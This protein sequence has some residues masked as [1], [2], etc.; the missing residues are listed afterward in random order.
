MH[1]IKPVLDLLL[2][3]SLA[4][5]I[6]L[7]G[8]IA[9]VAAAAFFVSR[10][11]TPAV[12]AVAIV[13]EVFSGNWKYIHIPL[14]AD[15]LLMLFGLFLLFWRGT[16]ELGSRKL[17]FSPIHLL[18]CALV[19]YVV[20]SAWVT[21]TLESSLGFYAILDRLGVVPFIM[22]AVAPLVFYTR[23]ARNTLLVA[24]VLLGAYLGCTAVAEGIPVHALIFPRY[25]ADPMLG[26]HFGRARGPFLEGVADGLSMF[27]CGTAAAVA[28]ASWTD[29]RARLLCYGVIAVSI[30]GGIFTLTRTVWVG[31]VFGP[32]IAMLWNPRLRRWIPA[33][34]AGGAVVILAALFLIPGLDSK[35]GGRASEVSPIWDRYNTNDAAIRAFVAHP[36][37]GIGWEE[38]V[39]KGPD[40]LRQADTY[41]LTGS[42]LEVHNVFLSHLVELGIPGLAM[43]A[44]AL[45]STVG[46]AALRRGPPELYPWRLGMIAIFVFYL[47]AANLGPMSYPLPNLLLWMWAGIVAAD[48]YS[49]ERVERQLPYNGN[50]LELTPRETTVRPGGRIQV[51]SRSA[52]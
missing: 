22:F 15:R 12:L 13:S 35:V 49:T 44:L 3:P 34:V 40:Y 28:L 52:P 5:A 24:L 17:V 48:R 42:G 41:P 43:W 47:I 29:R 19:L 16:H 46:G 50:R 11:S 2:H 33:I 8:L 10:L 1:R 7:V 23:Q 21:G 9:V 31:D 37:F 32:L 30:A 25:V 27:M 45:F 18:M 6:L 39:S 38:F 14:P 4:H 36:I 26:I 51:S 20:M